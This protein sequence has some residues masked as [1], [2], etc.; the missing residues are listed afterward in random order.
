MKALKFLFAAL[1]L[2]T[3]CTVHYPDPVTAITCITTG[4]ALVTAVI[5]PPKYW[6]TNLN[7][8]GLDVEVWKK[9]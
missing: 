5:V 7:V 4:G 2:L 8:G 6:S 1:A 9:H 3:L